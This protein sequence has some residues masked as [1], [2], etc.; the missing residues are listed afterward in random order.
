VCQGFFPQHV[1]GQEIWGTAAFKAEDHREVGGNLLRAGTGSIAGNPGAPL[2]LDPC[3]LFESRE[4]SIVEVL[5]ISLPGVV[6]GRD[7]TVGVIRSKLVGRHL[8]SVTAI[9][10]SHSHRLPYPTPSGKNVNKSW[11]SR[12]SPAALQKTLTA[13]PVLL[14]KKDMAA[15]FDDG[16][17]LAAC[18]F[19]PA[20]V[21]TVLLRKPSSSDKIDNQA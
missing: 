17:L 10:S 4:I 3:P 18:I 5:S 15:S 7:P 14:K 21:P 1:V 19:A 8:V 2:P 6:E 12:S 11:T 9:Q 16:F 20:I 13:L